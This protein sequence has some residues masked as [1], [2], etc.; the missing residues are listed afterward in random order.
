MTPSQ[1]EQAALNNAAWCDTLCRAHGASGEFDEAAWLNRHPVPRFYPNLVTL[2]S[3]G[4][5]AAQLAHVQDLIAS[6][7]AGQWAVKDSFSELDLA[8]LGFQ[9]LFEAT[10]LWRAPCAPLPDGTD[11]GIHWA[12]LQSEAQL[13]R[14]ENA[15]NGDPANHSSARQP[16]LFLPALLADPEIAF[17]AA[18]RGDELI[19]GAIANRTSTVVGLSNV[20]T[21]PEDAESFWM[22]CVATAVA[23]FPGRPLVGYES[24]P[25]LALAQAVGFESLQNLRIWVRPPSSS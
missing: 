3:Q 4:H 16:R 24:G 17:I 25:E 23:H 6:N 1:E 22:G 2:S 11:R 19:A 21:P 15:W 5:A 20:F 9:L 14:W 12:C 8:E 18:Y 7:L 13:D 10:W